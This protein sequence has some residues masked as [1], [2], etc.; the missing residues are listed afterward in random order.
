LSAS[1]R[2]RWALYAVGA[3]VAGWGVISLVT[4]SGVPLTEARFGIAVLLG[5]DA[6]LA[7]L[8]IGVGVL[9]ARWV[10]RRARAYVQA[11]LLVSAVVTLVA[12]PFVIG[13]GRQP[14]EPSSLPLDYGRGLLV[15]LAAVWVGVGA[16]AAV[17]MVA[18]FWRGSGRRLPTGKE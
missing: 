8:A 17:R 13:A 18:A 15:T 5:H 14:D 11:G 9:A 2:T 4:G 10:P 16:A 12:L 7:P 6:L 1:R 3:A